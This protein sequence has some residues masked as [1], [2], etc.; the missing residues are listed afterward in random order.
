MVTTVQSSGTPPPPPTTT[1]TIN[2]YAINDL[3]AEAAPGTPGSME[4]L[5]RELA[6]RGVPTVLLHTFSPTFLVTREGD[7]HLGSQARPIHGL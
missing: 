2:R 5:L 3:E 7:G 6:A 4:L 1:I